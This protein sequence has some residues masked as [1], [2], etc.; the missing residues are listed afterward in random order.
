MLWVAI[1]SGEPGKAFRPN[2]LT[3]FI[4]GLRSIAP[5]FAVVFATGFTFYAI[6][7]P[8]PLKKHWFN[9]L[10]LSIVYGAVGLIALVE[11]VDVS[12][13][14]YWNALYLSVPLV[15]LAISANDDGLEHMARILN[16]T[17]AIMVVASLSLFII[18]VVFLNVWDALIEPSRLLECDSGL[19]HDLT[20]GRLRDTGV[21]RYAAIA[22]LLALSGLWQPRLRSFWIVVLIISATLLLFTGARGSILGFCFGAIPLVLL[23]SGRSGI[24]LGT[25]TT[26]VLLPMFLITGAHETFLDNCILRTSS[27][28]SAAA[29]AVPDTT[30]A[31]QPSAAAA[32][33]P[34]T[35]GA[36]QPLAA[37]APVPDTTGATQ[38]SAAAAP[39]P[40]TTGATQPSA[41]AA[42]V[43]DTT[44]ATQPSA[45]AAQPVVKY[46]TDFFEFTGRTTV[47]AKGMDLF[48]ASPVIG[49][50]F[51]A[52]R[53]VLNTH[54]H[55]GFVH[56]MV[57][58]G[59]LGTI[60][61]LSAALFGWVLY[62]KIIRKLR[63]LPLSHKHLVIQ[64]GAILAFLTVRAFPE[65]TA[66]FFGIDWLILAPVLIYLYL[67]D[68]R[69]FASERLST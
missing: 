29:A 50:G 21:G 25:A 27:D 65:S 53:L 60:A 61:Y 47:W 11:S 52:D 26:A 6:N 68:S 66:A 51:H 10:S 30:G 46:Q 36:T 20:G 35:T 39:V 44:G 63:R 32:P 2:D 17:W 56:S 37:A 54:M 14:L 23:H 49:N 15:L 28:A 58:T 42:P 45:A 4:N 19:W 1:S 34:D 22:A 43:P 62:F 40:D 67:V 24:I 41:A 38:P 33:V 12:V 57:Q 3:S 7:Q 8:R 64:S 31:T 5:F 9:P 16:S 18:G 69:P 48:R 13:A 55:N 59:I